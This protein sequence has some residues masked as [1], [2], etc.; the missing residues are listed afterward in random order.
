MGIFSG[1]LIWLSSKAKG[2]KE[3][4]K[5]ILLQMRRGFAMIE[6]SPGTTEF[7]TTDLKQTVEKNHSQSYK[8]HAKSIEFASGAAAP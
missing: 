2:K 1:P 4:N 3:L 6:I 7:V 5:N 8:T